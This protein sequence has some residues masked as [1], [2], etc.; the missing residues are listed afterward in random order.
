MGPSI[1][2]SALVGSEPT[3]LFV[4]ARGDQRVNAAKEDDV[5]TDTDVM[6]MLERRVRTL[7]AARRLVLSV[8]GIAILVSFLGLSSKHGLTGAADN[9]KGNSNRTVTAREYVLIDANGRRRAE[10]SLQHMDGASFP[11]L[12]L[13]DEKGNIRASLGTYFDGSA[14][15]LLNN[16]T[17]VPLV[18]L[19]TLSGSG[20]GILRGD[21]S[22]LILFAG[23]EVAR[24]RF[25]IAEDK[26]STIALFDPNGRVRATLGIMK[27]GN[28]QF[29]IVE[30][31]IK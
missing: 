15:L 17:G 30:D 13:Y 5:E 10:L 22:S 12:R 28:Y 3:S 31:A 27:D 7:E 19:S 16:E 29:S 24:A 21:V 9:G 23:D 1:A 11:A 6:R 20:T 8:S 25:G 2:L 4:V 18:A 14:H 26:S